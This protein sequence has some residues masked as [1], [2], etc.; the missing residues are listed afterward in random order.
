M[1]WGYGMEWKVTCAILGVGGRCGRCGRY[2]R[3]G[4]TI[5]Y[6]CI[7]LEARRGEKGGEEGEGRG[8]ER[9]C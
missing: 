7:F 1:G 9:K 8:K 5:M 3:S 6:V 4:S 2:R